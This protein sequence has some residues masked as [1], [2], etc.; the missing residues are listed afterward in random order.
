MPPL[1][2]KKRRDRPKKTE[3]KGSEVWVRFKVKQ[4]ENGSAA[5]VNSDFHK[6]DCIIF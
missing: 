2:M 3:R 4:N 1:G 5:H 6:H